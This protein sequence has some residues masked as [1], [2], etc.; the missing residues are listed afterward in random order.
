MNW[1]TGDMLYKIY[2]RVSLTIGQSDTGQDS[3][4]TGLPI[5]TFTVPFQACTRF[6]S[7]NAVGPHSAVLKR[8]FGSPYSFSGALS[9]RNTGFDACSR[10]KENMTLSLLTS[11]AKRPGH[12]EYHS[13]KF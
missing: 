13:L 8:L 9:T 2:G 6:P 11:S 4:A 7:I 5:A 10:R 3:E 1:G 12:N